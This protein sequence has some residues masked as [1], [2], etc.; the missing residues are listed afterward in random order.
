[1]PNTLA[2]IGVQSVGT[3]IF[4][5]TAD[6]KWIV[7]GC[8]I[9]D[10]PWIT[11]RI[12]SLLLPENLLDLRVYCMIQ[13]SLFF[14]LV[15]SGSLALLAKN[16]YRIFLILGG[17]SIAHLLLDALQTKWAN[18]VHLMAPI[19][20]QLIELKFFWPESPLTLVLTGIGF[21]LALF[22][23]WRDRRMVIHTVS[24]RLRLAIS[25]LLLGCY[26]L[27][28][29][30]FFQGP[31]TADNHYV[32]TLLDRD[33]RTGKEIGFD[34]CYYQKE[35]NM[36]IVFTGEQFSIINN[37]PLEDGTISLLGTFVDNKTINVWKLHRHSKMRNLYSYLGLLILVLLWSI[38]GYKQK[39][40][41]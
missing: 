12:V 11:Q 40:T 27:F 39:I 29:F 28:P 33:N 31:Y 36:V 6:I 32:Q 8:V 17:N 9:P 35:N 21:G 41:H 18:G 4:D 24:S 3:K 5:R 19:N 34:R 14:C 7:L 22:F 25:A 10:L 26:F 38:A 20:W 2:H 30:A 16:S 23:G 37:P 15:I 13:A 1:M